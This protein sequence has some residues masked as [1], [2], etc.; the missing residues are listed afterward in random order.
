MNDLDNLRLILNTQLAGGKCPTSSALG[1]CAA[2]VELEPEHYEAY[3]Y[4][5]DNH[6]NDFDLVASWFKEAGAYEVTISWTLY[7]E[8]NGITQ[9]YADDGV[10]QLVVT[11]KLKENEPL[12]IDRA[13]EHAPPLGSE[14][15]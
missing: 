12:P 7:D 15:L 10:R 13:F 1:E 5:W 3:V 14:V 9:G 11:F 8:L 2:I 4:L 6:F